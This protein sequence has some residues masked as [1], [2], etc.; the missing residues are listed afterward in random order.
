MT[1]PTTSIHL[2]HL[3]VA[4]TLSLFDCAEE[5]LLITGNGKALLLKAR[6]QLY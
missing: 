1:H 4:F 3:E 5:R 2:Q 6:Q